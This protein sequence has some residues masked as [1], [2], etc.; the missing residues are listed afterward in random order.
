MTGRRLLARVPLGHHADHPRAE[1]RLVH[2]PD[3]RGTGHGQRQHPLGEQHGLAQR[4]DRQ[5]VG[6]VPARLLRRVAGLG[7][8]AI[9]SS[10]MSS[11][12]WSLRPPRGGPHRAGRDGR[13]PTPPG[14]GCSAPRRMRPEAHQ[15]DRLLTDLAPSVVPLLFF[16]S[17]RLIC[18]SIAPA[19]RPPRS[20]S[21]RRAEPRPVPEGVPRSS[22][23]G[24]RRAAL[25]SSRSLAMS[26]FRL[27]SSIAR[28]SACTAAGPSPRPTPSP[29][30]IPRARSRALHRT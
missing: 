20:P 6:D 17:A 11:L 30:A 21:P 16:F 25:R 5:L 2:Q 19:G 4:E 3:G 1:H 28:R 26:S 12:T 24:R 13:V 18:P 14:S 10:L 7:P 27:A 29:S 8:I 23:G 15:V 9:V 22:P